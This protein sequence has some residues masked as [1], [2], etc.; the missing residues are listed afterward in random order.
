[1]ACPYI[2]GTDERCSRMLTLRN[3]QQA[4]SLC[5]YDYHNCPTYRTLKAL[6]V[7][8]AGAAKLLRMAS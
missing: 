6:S 1:M 2:D 4:V 8:R 3:I 7:R 5:A